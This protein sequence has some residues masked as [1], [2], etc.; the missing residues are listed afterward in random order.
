MMKFAIAVTAAA[1][2]LHTSPVQAQETLPGMDAA[3]TKI[4]LCLHG[5]QVAFNI[6][7]DQNGITPQVIPADKDGL[8]KLGAGTVRPYFGCMAKKNRCF[9]ECNG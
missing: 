4:F 3:E 5:C 6:C 9:A 1:I 2:A 8:F 7:M